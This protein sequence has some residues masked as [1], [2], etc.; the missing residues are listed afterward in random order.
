[1]CPSLSKPGPHGLHQ[2]QKGRSPV[3]P[4]GS[5]HPR[6]W[7]RRGESHPRPKILYSGP[8]RAFPVIWI[9]SPGTPAG[10]A[11]F[12]PSPAQARPSAP[13]AGP[14]GTRAQKARQNCRR[15]ET[16]IAALLIRSTHRWKGSRDAAQDRG[17]A[18]VPWLLPVGGAFP[19]DPGGA[20]DVAPGVPF[21]D[22]VPLV[23]ELLPAASPTTS[24]TRGPLK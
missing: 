13:R 2:A 1:M 24:L 12:G 10:R 6:A 20:L 9:S 18:P 21:G 3:E 19:P 7:W 17:E 15:R 8:L 23:V 5:A 4:E 22:V 14:S 11:P 16:G